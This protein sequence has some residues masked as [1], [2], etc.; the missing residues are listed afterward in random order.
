MYSVHLTC[1][2]SEMTSGEIFAKLNIKDQNNLLLYQKQILSR[3]VLR[4][5]SDDEVDSSLL[6][7]D[8][9]LMS[10]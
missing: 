3:E 2:H 9:V 5:Y 6:G 4:S 1:V 8:A 10:K 7:N